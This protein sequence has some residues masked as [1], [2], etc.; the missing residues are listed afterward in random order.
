MVP[1]TILLRKIAVFRSQE[2]LKQCRL[3]CTGATQKKTCSDAGVHP[4]FI[5]T[6]TGRIAIGLKLMWP[7][8]N[9]NLFISFLVYMGCGES[10]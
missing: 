9:A 3:R 8:H 7:S 1:N 10:R 4:A 6:A 5:D 2:G